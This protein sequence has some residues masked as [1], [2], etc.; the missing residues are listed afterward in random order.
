[1]TNT[2]L[3]KRSCRLLRL[4][5]LGVVLCVVPVLF[6]A[7]SIFADAGYVMLNG[8][9]TQGNALTLAY[10]NSV[11][12]GSL[13]TYWQNGQ[14][15]IS[16]LAST[17][18]HYELVESVGHRCVTATGTAVTVST[19]VASPSQLMTLTPQGA[20]YIVQASTGNCLASQASFS[21][22]QAEPCSGATTQNWAFSGATP[23]VVGGTPTA[24]PTTPPT[25]TTTVTTPTSGGTTLGSWSMLNEGATQ[26]NSM[27]LMYGISRDGGGLTTYWPQGNGGIN[28][29]AMANSQY[30]LVENTGF[31][32]VTVVGSSVNVAGCTGA[33]GQLFT[34]SP[35]T[36]GSYSVQAT[37]TGQCL[38]APAAFATVAA[39][40]CNVA[41]NERWLFSGK[42]SLSSVLS[43]TTTTTP[44][45]TS[46]ATTPATPTVPTPSST[47][48][49]GYHLTFDDEFTTLNLSDQSGTGAKWYTHTV[50]CCLYD[51][52]APATPTYMAGATAPAGQNPYSLASG[53]GLDIRLQKTN[54]SWYSG[55]LATVDSNGQG[56]A[57]QYGYFEMK[58][59]FPEGLGT[60]PAFWLLNQAALTAHAS[61]GE[62]D[63]VES[64][65]QFPTYIN[66][67]LHDWTPPATAP[68]YKQ[69]AV[70]N[71]SSGFHTIG[72]LW[73][74]T[75]MTFYCDGAALYS[76]PTPPIMNQPYYPIVD[77]GLG[78][79]WPTAQTPQ[80]SD[81]I[82]QYIRVYAP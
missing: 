23:L 41:L 35:Q 3:L 48:P 38:E 37:G 29:V 44:V 32:C 33:T 14:V 76:L 49:A 19:C 53:G 18:N 72:M 47:V 66:T 71:L 74:A 82:V 62:I 8:G 77:L 27:V 36:D 52:S 59:K 28:V 20:G 12:G 80:Q 68:G 58:A 5:R 69:A 56:F 13:V 81:M 51:T 17:N 57:Q 50:Q 42:A 15:Q 60:W 9:A 43:T 79:G 1:M 45:A 11:N 64:Y 10:G 4:L 46:P 63:I 54:G 34:L 31:R 26:G 73:T 39:L 7:N 24:T 25:T 75:T 22:V 40:P 55:V 6:P 67:T 21:P 2:S 61:P 70:A 16:V 78:G 30:E 65:M